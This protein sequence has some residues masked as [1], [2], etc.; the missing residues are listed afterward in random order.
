ME[1]IVFDGQQTDEVV[2]CAIST[3]PVRRI[4][5]DSIVVISGIFLLGVFFALWQ[6][7]ALPFGIPLIGVALAGLWIVGG[8]VWQ[9]MVM[10]ENRAYIT[11]RRFIR[12]ERVTPVLTTKRSLFWGD[13]LKAKAFSDNVFWK[14]MNIG[15]LQIEAVAA[16][17]EDIRVPY[18]YYAE[19]LANYIDKI[20]YITKTAPETIRS[21]KPF[22]AQSKWKRGVENSSQ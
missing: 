4:L 8:V 20:L 3:H 15:T 16:E 1:H 17:G 13:T 11:D 14:K 6:T 5:N 7:D 9:E 12:F 2:L 10:K 21:I 22:I 18:V 19:D